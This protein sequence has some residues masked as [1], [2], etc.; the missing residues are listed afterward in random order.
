[1]N[2]TPDTPDSQAANPDMF[3][4]LGAI[5]RQLHD[6]LKELGYADKLQGTVEQLPD[7]QSRLSYIARLTGEAAEKVLSQVEEGKKEQE[8]LAQRGRE[9]ADTIRRVPALAKAMPELLE[10]STDVVALAEKTD[11]RL[12]E[13]MMAQ[14]FH[15]LTGQ[16]IARVVGLA[17]TIEEQLLGLLLESV[18]T[19]QPGQDKAHE[20]AGPVVNAEGRTDVVTDQKQVDDLLASLG[21]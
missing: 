3:R 8:Q 20:L 18:P 2:H 4:K 14:D 16:V 12:T 21:F 10:W 17:G 1:M 19:G 9:L 11:A 5:T 15:D 7:A 13:I 6:A